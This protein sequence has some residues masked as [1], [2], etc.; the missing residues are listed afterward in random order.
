MTVRELMD[1]LAE[2]PQGSQV[3][4]CDKDSEYAFSWVLDDVAVDGDQEPV[5]Y[6]SHFHN[7]F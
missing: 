4:I 7:T 1:E 3:R 5:V 2:L 6:L